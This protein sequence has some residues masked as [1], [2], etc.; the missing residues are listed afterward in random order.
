MSMMMM[1]MTCVMATAIPITIISI[2]IGITL[3]ILNTAAC[4]YR[5]YGLKKRRRQIQME[6][7]LENLLSTEPLQ[8]EKSPDM[9]L[10]ECVEFVIATAFDGSDDEETM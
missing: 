6:M 5:K 1:V 2:T 7:D 3:A 4:L 8:V 10:K 9:T